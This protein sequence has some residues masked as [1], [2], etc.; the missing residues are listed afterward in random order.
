MQTMNFNVGSDRRGLVADVQNFKI[1]NDAKN[2]VQA[3]QFEGEMR[4]VVVNV[5]E[6][7]IPL[8]L[9]GTTIW[10][11]GLMSDGK[12]RIIDA[13]HGTILSPST[14]QFRFEF[15]YAAFATFGSYKQSFFKIV[16]DG[17]SIATLEF[18]LDVLVNLVED[19][20]VPLDYITPFQDLYAKLDDIYQNAD[21]D[22]QVMVTKWQQQITELI[23]GLNADYASIQTTVNGLNEKLDSIQKQ[24][25]DGGL[26][27][28][29]ELE[30]QLDPIKQAFENL[31]NKL[32]TLLTKQYS[33]N[34][35]YQASDEVAPLFKDEIKRVT[36]QIDPTKFNFVVNTDAH[37]QERTTYGRFMNAP[38][39]QHLGMRH[40]SNALALAQNADALIL[41]G[42][43]NHPDY[44]N[45]EVG[46]KDVQTTASKI[47]DNDTNS[48][49][50]MIMGNHDVGDS[51]ILFN[52]IGK[53]K[54]D[55]I[56]SEAEMK[57][58][59]RTADSQFGE[60]RNGDS[61]Y[62]Y[63]DYPAKKIRLIGIE[64]ED[65]QEITDSDGYIKHV[66]LRTHV[67]AQ[68][69]LN[70]IANTALMT[71]PSDY[72]VVMFGHA[73][74]T[75]DTVNGETDKMWNFGI[76]GDVIDA[77]KKGLA[78]TGSS[79][80]TDYKVN[81][82]ADYTQRGIGQ[83]VGYFCGHEHTESMYDFHG[84]RVVKLLH[85]LCLPGPKN[86]VRQ[87]DTLTEDA[88]SLI[89]VDAANRTVNII[90]FGAAHDRQFSY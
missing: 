69:Q 74:L 16:R 58:Y 21:S 40:F 85:S 23:T 81:I 66:R 82:S 34:N 48:D 18:T 89:S 12:T 55:E 80:V 68:E 20:I 19:G 44:L 75:E 79:S 14:G 49:R 10:F 4:T 65:T 84:L 78:Y 90:G 24:I 27:T 11:E 2:W 72:H 41:G 57:Q 31:D 45:I 39:T 5:M 83:F 51:L 53:V 46:K 26:L 35:D 73:F 62:F 30:T 70:W 71:T 64:T 13:K 1:G 25:K 38:K 36:D 15:P 33:M 22:I 87:A 47:I 76:L 54:L 17:K 50:F 88:N 86:E 59:Y 3:R 52:G 29:A 60:V 56:I 63:K 28:Q 6:G 32:E 8:N 7:T 43:N 61:L 42:D 9:T 67:L 77:W 37:Y